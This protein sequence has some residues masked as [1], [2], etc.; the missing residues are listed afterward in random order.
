MVRWG[1]IYTNCFPIRGT[2]ME[3]GPIGAFFFASM[4]AGAR[5]CLD[6]LLFV[7][8]LPKAVPWL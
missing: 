7:R 3:K 1:A 8:G 5:N 4:V 6:L 2:E